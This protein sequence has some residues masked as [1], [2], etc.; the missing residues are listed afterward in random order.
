M[1]EPRRFVGE[2]WVE[3][4]GAGAEDEA[5]G[6]DGLEG[7]G[8]G[9]GRLGWGGEVDV[10]GLRTLVESGG[11]DAAGLRC[12]AGSVLEAGGEHEAD[13]CCV[14]ELTT[15]F[16]VQLSNILEQVFAATSAH[17]IP[18]WSHRFRK[19]QKELG[20][21]IRR[22]F[23]VVLIDSASLKSL[24]HPENIADLL[25]QQISHRYDPRRSCSH[26][27]SLIRAVQIWHC[28]ISPVHRCIVCKCSHRSSSSYTVQ[29]C[30]K[31]P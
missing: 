29:V 11:C 27:Y 31:S 25:L 8:G 15:F 14:A 13:V 19:L 2:G 28:G 30:P 18:K 17:N 21:G 5:F 12:D 24:I 10:P 4:G 6:A 1:F 23:A 7:C 20:L 26:H 3:R 9:G 22:H 16:L